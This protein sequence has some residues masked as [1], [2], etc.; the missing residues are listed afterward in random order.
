MFYNFT[1]RSIILFLGLYLSSCVT[2]FG[3]KKNEPKKPYSEI[4]VQK[5]GMPSNQIEGKERSY[6]IAT[7]REAKRDSVK[8]VATLASGD[9]QSSEIH[10]RKVLRKRP[11][12][13]KALAILTASLAQQKNFS[14]AAFYARELLKVE[15]NHP[16][17]LN[18]MGLSYLMASNATM[19]DF[20]RARDYFEKAMEA[21]P[22]EAAAALNIAY[23]HLELGRPDLAYEAFSEAKNRCDGCFY[24][25]LGRGIS[26]GRIGKMASA[27]N[28]FQDILQQDPRNGEAMYRL[29]LVLKNG[30][31]DLKGSREL[32][33]KLIDEGRSDDNLKRRAY[34]LA[35][36]LEDTRSTVADKSSSMNPSAESDDMGSLY[37]ALET[38]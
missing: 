5:A 22:K 37:Q 29:A 9:A 28:E 18:V 21:S 1:T 8:M 14:M 34:V 10:A 11:G 3:E 32:L 33:D 36:K 12:D 2:P 35:R 13:K 38:E 27:K 19:R 20:I 17:A 24:A 16:L 31:N 30:Y 25:S 6:W 7:N 26:A 15:E 23:L 4:I